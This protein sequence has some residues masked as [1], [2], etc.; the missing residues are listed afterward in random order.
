MQHGSIIRCKGTNTNKWPNFLIPCC[1]ADTQKSPKT[2]VL[3]RLP[4]F[5]SAQ[6]DYFKASVGKPSLHEIPSLLLGQLRDANT[7]TV[8]KYTA[9][10][11]FCIAVLHQ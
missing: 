11:S 7:L 5:F 1:T 4:N 9:F 3:Q 10:Y 8:N 6:A 2:D